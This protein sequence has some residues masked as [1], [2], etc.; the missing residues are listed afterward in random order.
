MHQRW[1]S[2]TAQMMEV[3]DVTRLPHTLFKGTMIL[4]GSIGALSFF[5][6]QSFDVS[7]ALAFFMLAY[8]GAE[9]IC[10]IC[11]AFSFCPISLKSY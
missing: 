11:V 3:I 9:Y 10:S 6:L 4:F 2:T 1:M 7:C 5:V 8:F